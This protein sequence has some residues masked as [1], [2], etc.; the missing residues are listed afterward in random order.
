MDYTV[1]QGDTLSGI[2][3][4][5]NTT[6]ADLT[7]L[8]NI[9][10]PNLLK[11]GQKILVG[12]QPASVNTTNTQAV[13]PTQNIQVPN[14]ANTPIPVSNLTNNI[15][16]SNVP[17]VPPIQT[18][19]QPNLAQQI[20][21]ATRVEETDAQRQSKELSKKITDLLPQTM[22][23]TQALA[24]AQRQYG[25]IDLTK[26]LN[27]INNLI[28]TK[29]AELNQDD[30]RLAQGIQNIEDKPIAMEFITGQQASLQRQAAISRAMKASEIGVLNARAAAL[31]NNIV[32]ANQLAQQ[33][34]D[35]KYAPIKEAVQLYKDQ[36]EALQPIL[37]AD[38]K[39]T[40][41]EQEI[42]TQLAFQEIEDKKENEKAINNLV[43]NAAAQGASASLLD[44]ASLAKTPMQAASILGEYSGDYWKIQAAKSQIA[45]D[46]A[47][48]AKIYSDMA[49]DKV[50]NAAAGSVKTV[51]NSKGEQVSKTAQTLM[52]S[53]NK[54]LNNTKG[55]KGAVGPVSSKLPTVSGK[56]SNFEADF[57]QLKSVLTL[58]NISYLKGTG[59]ISDKEQGILE[60]AATSL[61]LKMDQDYFEKTLR[62]FKSDLKREN[63]NLDDGTSYSSAAA[64]EWATSLMKG[65]NSPNTTFGYQ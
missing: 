61:D 32:L 11:I 4:A 1:Q 56:T 39:K 47:Q 64:N 42:R 10:N 8:N 48:R 30:I 21:D 9:Q 38:E 22:G 65:Y 63:P 46:Q 2:A 50:K 40:A 27:D 19:A 35:L 49:N 29:N 60:K 15:S 53:I 6:V 20:L 37:S 28:T 34:V 45:T 57:A 41:R 18:Q 5:N 7:K 17:V 13:P 59:Q 44:K 62:E 58:D 54:L 36:L 33:A 3:K 55:L 51:T 25:V 52:F 16:Q 23:Q 43:M 14:I 24:D 26:N 31:Q 12:Q